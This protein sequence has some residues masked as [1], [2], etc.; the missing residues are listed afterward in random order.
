MANEPQQT[1]D[2]PK[3]AGPAP[4]VLIGAIVA[5]LVAGAAAGGFLIAPRLAPKPTAVGAAADHEAAGKKP[6]GKHGGGHGENAKGAVHRIENLIV[7]PAGSQGT[8]FLMTTIAIEVSDEKVGDALR[9]HDAEVRDIVIATLES[10][11]LE[12]L[13]RPGS[14]DSVKRKIEKALAPLVEG[15]EWVHVYLPQFVIQ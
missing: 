10:Q 14:R 5:A 13:T 9:D 3:A 12:M 2:A 1:Q 11:S 8:R 15:A 6:K 4:L 7:N